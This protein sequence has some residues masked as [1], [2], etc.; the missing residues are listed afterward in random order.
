[1]NKGNKEFLT[2]Q[3]GK[4]DG[5]LKYMQQLR[6]AASW[7]MERMKELGQKG[8]GHRSEEIFILCIVCPTPLEANT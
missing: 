4:C 7:P 6:T 3:Q 8:L 1:V 2:K 5:D